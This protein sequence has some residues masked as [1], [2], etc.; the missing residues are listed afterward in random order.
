MADKNLY[1]LPAVTTANDSDLLHVNQGGVS[2]DV[3]ITK[4]NL[5]KEVNSSIT[6]L[7]NSLTKSSVTVTGVSGAGVTIVANSSFQFNNIVVINVRITVSSDKPSGTNL[8]NVPAPKTTLT[9]GSGAVAC[10]ANAGA[11]VIAASGVLA[12]SSGITAGAAYIFSAIYEKA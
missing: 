9:G 12:C 4:Q 8:L 5:L 7:N 3:K 10:A 11:A 6:S 2:S 1:N